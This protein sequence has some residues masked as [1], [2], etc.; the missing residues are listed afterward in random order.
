ML[1][2]EIGDEAFK[3]AVKSYLQKHKFSNVD[4]EDFLVEA[5]AASGSDLQEFEWKWLR[6]VAFNYEDAIATLEDY[7]VIQRYKR[8]VELRKQS[9]GQKSQKLFNLLALP[10]KYSGPE[11]IYQLADVSPA[12]AGRIYERAFYTNNPWVRQAIAQTVSKVPAAMKVNYERLLNDDS[13]I[14]RE[15]ALMNLWTSF[16]KDRHQYLDKMKGVQG[17]SNHNVEILW[18][19]LAI[20]TLDYEEAYVRDHFFRLTRFTGNRYSFETREQAFTK[21]YQLQLFEPKSLKNLIEACFHHNWRFA[22]TCRQILDEV[23]KIE[24][25]RKE[26]KKLD[27][28]EE[29][30]KQLLAEKLG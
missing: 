1:R 12:A 28:S 6:A 3:T 24:H 22:Q 19:A 18:L 10:D 29:K 14:T 26:L 8:T 27:I 23:V 21:L 11:A 15:L 25:Y 17:F 5:R 4:T 30:E 20:S 2:K 16:P 9:F 13:Y 7:P